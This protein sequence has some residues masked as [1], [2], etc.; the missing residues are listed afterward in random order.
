MVASQ[1]RGR[2]L[3]KLDQTA[4]PVSC[5][6]GKR[7]GSAVFIIPLDLLDRPFPAV[8]FVGHPTLDHRERSRFSALRH[9]FNR[10]RKGRDSIK[11]CLLGEIFSNLAIGIRPRLLTAEQFHDQ[12]IAIEDGGVALL[13]RAAPD[14]ERLLR[15]PT[16]PGKRGAWYAPNH[17]APRV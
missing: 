12:T 17:S 9:V 13:R 4:L 1:G 15:F 2:L 3:G 16:Q 6:L 8:A 10:P 7:D 11:L 5:L 14:G